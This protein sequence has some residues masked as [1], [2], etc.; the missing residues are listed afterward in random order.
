MPARAVK[1]RATIRFDLP[2]VSDPT[3]FPLFCHPTTPCPAVDC[4][5]VSVAPTNDGG[6]H[7]RY[8]VS[9]QPGALCLPEPQAAGP[10]DG[11]WQHTCCE[12]FVATG[13]GSA[14]REFNFSPSGQW[15]VY[16]FSDYR[17]PDTAFAPQTAPQIS[18]RQLADGFE[19]AATLAA[20]LL[21]DQAILQLGVTAVIEAA[22]GSKSYWALTHCAAQ[23]DFHPRQS[24]TLAF[25]RNAS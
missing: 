15:A 2:I 25:D 5:V 18:L 14:Y 22:D 12:L 23:P 21:P 8:R 19:L 20:S 24:F 3:L 7:L 1:V 6:L 13:R 4:V 9:S 16:A 17:Q 10:A 11:L